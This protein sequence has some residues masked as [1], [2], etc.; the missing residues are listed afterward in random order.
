MTLREKALKYSGRVFSK[1]DIATI[2]EMIER[3]PGLSRTALSHLVCER[4][5]WYMEDGDIK[6]VSCRKALLRMNEDGLIKLPPGRSDPT[7]FKREITFSEETAP[8]AF[9]P[10]DI[11]D[12]GE[13]QFDI[14]TSTP[15]GK[16]WNEYIHRYHY[17]GYTSLP[18]A[19]LKYLVKARGKVVALLGFGAAAWKILPRDEFIGWSPDERE[20]NL[21]FIVNNARF[22]V[23]PWIRCQNL[24]SRIFSDIFR[25]LT[26]DWLERYEYAPV[27][28]ETFVEKDRFDG[29]CYR[30]SNWQCLGETKGRGKNDDHND[31]SQP[32]KTIWIYPLQ[33]NFRK[34]LR[35]I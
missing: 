3:Q 35:S 19:Q 27:L 1:E 17:L 6:E 33:Q 16:L 7:R 8:Y 31:R 32:I 4:F 24:A 22:L 10:C 13:L 12:L 28:V 23:L 2:Q 29:G 11:S 5:E 30:A 9:E 20:Q 18:G 26:R 14:V 21:R 15:R 34:T 25:R